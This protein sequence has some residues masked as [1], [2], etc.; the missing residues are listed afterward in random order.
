VTRT[1][2]EVKGRFERDDKDATFE[3][4]GFDYQVIARQIVAS[5][6]ANNKQ[7][8]TVSRSPKVANLSDSIT[9]VTLHDT[10]LGSSTLDIQLADP[11]YELF[12]FFDINNDG[13]LDKVE[14]QYPPNTDNWWRLTQ[15]GISASAGSAL[16][17]TL[18]FME[19]PVVLLMHRHG[20]KKASRAKVTRA[21]FLQS[22]VRDVKQHRLRFSC[23][24]LHKKQPIAGTTQ[25]NPHGVGVEP[26]AFTGGGP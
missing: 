20:P 17:L 25:V 14:I 19:R 10:Y 1:G 22:L 13:H 11:E 12:E 21:E 8:K 15:L 18:T 24:E 7:N 16:E 2:H 23:V 3:L 6:T 5:R 4:A 9:S 26:L